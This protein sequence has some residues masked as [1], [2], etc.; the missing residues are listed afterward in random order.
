LLDAPDLDGLLAA[1]ARWTPAVG[2][3]DVDLA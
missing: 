2:R 1:F 3:W